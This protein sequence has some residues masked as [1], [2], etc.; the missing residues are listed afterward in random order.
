MAM[1]F[2]ETSPFSRGFAVEV[3]EGGSL[4]VHMKPELR[5]YVGGPVPSADTK[6]HAFSNVADLLAW[7]ASEANTGTYLRPGHDLIN[8]GGQNVCLGAS[9]GTGVY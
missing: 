4:V 1:P 6:K 8:S 5:G 2:V 9:N 7:L 3:C